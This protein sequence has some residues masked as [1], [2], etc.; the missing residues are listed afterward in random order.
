MRPL[1]VRVAQHIL[2]DKFT[3]SVRPLAFA[4]TIE[5]HSLASSREQLI[6]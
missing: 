3:I 4:K 1:L 5:S 6:K 2:I